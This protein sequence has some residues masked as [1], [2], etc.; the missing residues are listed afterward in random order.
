MRS[1]V[2]K[3]RIKNGYS[4]APKLRRQYKAHTL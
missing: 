4:A 2:K 3:K 1:A